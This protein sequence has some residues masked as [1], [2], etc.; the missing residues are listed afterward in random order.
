MIL[1]DLIGVDCAIIEAVQ[2]ILSG[3]GGFNS[4]HIEMTIYK[5]IT[6]QYFQLFGQREGV[7]VQTKEGFPAHIS[8]RG[9][10]RYLMRRMIAK[11]HILKARAIF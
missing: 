2:N 11:H 6:L 5:S 10:Q 4:K 7:E 8:Q 9:G 1:R 3:Q